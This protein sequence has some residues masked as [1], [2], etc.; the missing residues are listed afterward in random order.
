MLSWFD[1]VELVAERTGFEPLE[2][3]ISKLKGLT[4]GDI[5]TICKEEGL[6]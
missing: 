5:S 6:S 2:V 1:Q 4:Q 3:R